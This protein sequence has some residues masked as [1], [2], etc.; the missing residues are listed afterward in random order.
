MLKDKLRKTKQELVVSSYLMTWKK[1]LEK[2]WVLL[3]SKNGKDLGGNLFRIL[4]EL[5]QNPAYKSYEI[6]VSANRNKIGTIKNLLCNYK[7]A[8]VKM[9]EKGSFS[10]AK[11]Y[12]RAGYI[13]TDTSYPLWYI[14]R[15]GQILLNTWHGTPLKA[16]GKDDKLQAWNMGNIQKSH[17][18]S[19]YLVY[20][21][22]YME[23][24]ML[25]AYQLENLYGGRILSL[26]YPR[27]SIFF[28]DK[29]R[30][31]MMTKV[32]PHKKKL[33]CYMPTWRGSGSYVDSAGQTKTYQRYF[34]EL[35]QLLQEDEIFMVRL[36]PFLA[37][38]IDYSVYKHIQAFPEGLEP[39]DVLNCSD[40]LVTDY[41]SVFFDYANLGNPIV[42]FTYDLEDYKKE[43]G[44]YYSIDDFPFPQA[45]NPKEL[46][47]KMRMGKSYDDAAFRAYFCKYDRKD[48]AKALCQEVF[49]GA[50]TGKRLA[51]NGKE[52]VLILAG[53]LIEGEDCHAL[54]QLIESD[55]ER[56]YYIAFRAEAMKE[57]AERLDRIAQNAVLLPL[58]GTQIRAFR[59]Q[60]TRGYYRRFYMRNFAHLQMDRYIMYKNISADNEKALLPKSAMDLF[61][62][63][64][65]S[66][67]ENWWSWKKFIDS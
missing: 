35:D 56:N 40:C 16:M 57:Q 1:P 5:T 21:S 28:D 51:F 37:D 32:N 10:Y 66:W 61:F 50:D 39:Y 42:L 55:K 27:N 53:D 64:G 23:E 8:G 62:G 7:I 9:I 41:S 6:F 46:V 18:L 47:E 52:K 12:A 65:E 31:K 48:G 15:P 60:I 2:K 29:A 45:R 49:S 36:H 63:R 25:A 30:K 43:R 33:I 26:G 4:Q 38:G 67:M 13:F 34:R 3:D 14:K 20:P 24:T 17:L 59:E 11:L 44:V 19:D 22:N 58:A 54:K